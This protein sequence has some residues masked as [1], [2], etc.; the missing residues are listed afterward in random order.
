MAPAGAAQG[1]APT[2]AAADMPAAAAVAPAEVG[3]D[4][5]G[6]APADSFA[7]PPEAVAR[8]GRI[9]VAGN[10]HTDS[11]RIVRTFDVPAGSRFA[12][13][14]VRRGIRKLFALGLFSDVWVE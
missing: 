8:V 1:G 11:A 5:V 10:A 6:A 2:S 13:D 14:A 3:G 7:V 4:S 9:R 12:E